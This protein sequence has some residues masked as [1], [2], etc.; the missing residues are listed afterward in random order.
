[1]GRR[2][3]LGIVGLCAVGALSAYLELRRSDSQ[4][5]DELV[6]ELAADAERHDVRAMASFVSA[7]YHD[8]RGLSRDGVL[9]A[10]G[11]YLGRQGWSRIIPVKVTVE[12]IQGA[13][14]TAVVQLILAQADHVAKGRRISEA[15][16][17]DLEL[18]REGQRWQLL[19]AEDWEVPP[20]S[21]VRMP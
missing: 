7:S 12:R 15:L 11:G 10:L 5:I 4:R 20:E 6:H 1:M 18:A 13:R 19:S 14:A 8:E 9:Q 17:I 16:R 3:T 21:L 2:L